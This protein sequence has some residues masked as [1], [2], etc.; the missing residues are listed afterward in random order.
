MVTVI[1]FIVIGAIAWFAVTQYLGVVQSTSRVINDALGTTDAEYIAAD[2]FM[3]GLIMG[4]LAIAI[5][6]LAI[7]VWHYSQAKSLQGGG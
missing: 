6:G 2:Q 4:I 1:L 3:T 7:W 5:F